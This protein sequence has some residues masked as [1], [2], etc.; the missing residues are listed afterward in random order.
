MLLRKGAKPGTEAV[1]DEIMRAYFSP[2]DEVDADSYTTQRDHWRERAWAKAIEAT[3]GDAAAH[4]TELEQAASAL[5]LRQRAGETIIT[6]INDE[7]VKIEVLKNT[8][9]REATSRQ[10]GGKR[11]NDDPAY[12]ALVRE[13]RVLLDVSESLA[14]ALQASGTTAGQLTA[15]SGTTATAVDDA[16]GAGGSV[17]LRELTKIG[18]AVGLV[19]TLRT[20]PEPTET[21]DAG[22]DAAER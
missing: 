11:R 15:T 1:Y 8:G 6:R 22:T 12:R 19:P 21:S 7:G 17:T 20:A 18:G 10:S 16:L 9:T 14:E 4:A 13:E 2:S 5:R 3:E